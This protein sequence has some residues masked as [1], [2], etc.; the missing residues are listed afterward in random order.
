M[1][2]ELGL[3]W[4]LLCVLEIQVWVSYLGEQEQDSMMFQKKDSG[5]QCSKFKGRLCVTLDKSP[6]FPR[7][8]FANTVVPASSAGERSNVTA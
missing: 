2:T 8:Q 5:Y 4:R 1:R 6:N 7:L 3:D